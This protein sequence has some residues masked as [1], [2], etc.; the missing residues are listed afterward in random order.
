MSTKAMTNSNSGRWD[1]SEHK[2]FLELLEAHGKDWKK[3]SSLIPTRTEQQVRSHAQKF[4]L[5][6]NRRT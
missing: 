1:H 3:I 4:Y 6:L 5:K 2:Y